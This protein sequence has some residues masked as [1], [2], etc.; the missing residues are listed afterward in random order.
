MNREI[1]AY[2]VLS[3]TT[4]S[5]AS[6]SFWV[7]SWLADDTLYS[8][9][10]FTSRINASPDK[11]ANSVSSRYFAMA[12]GKNLFAHNCVI[13][14]AAKCSFIFLYRYKL[15]FRGKDYLLEYFEQFASICFFLI[16]SDK[17][18]HE[19]VNNCELR[20]TDILA[21]V[22]QCFIIRLSVQS[23]ESTI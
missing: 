4:N 3:S 18:G 6:I 10:I 14:S 9:K 22:K 8:S 12:P 15:C 19:T 20:P 7:N 13:V 17:V 2:Y 11:S 16:V 21:P 1:S 23:Y 5:I